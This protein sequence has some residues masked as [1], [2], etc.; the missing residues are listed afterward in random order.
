MIQG[1]KIDKLRRIFRIGRADVFQNY[2]R[3]ILHLFTIA[4]QSI[5]KLHILLGERSFHAVDHIIAVVATL[6]ANIHRR[7]PIDWHIGRLCCSRIHGHK[8]CH[9]FTGGI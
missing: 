8:A 9:V 4:P 5:K 1:H 3:D 6:T 2:V 7:K